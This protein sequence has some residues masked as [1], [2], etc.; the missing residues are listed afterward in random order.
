MAD[1]GCIVPVSGLEYADEHFVC[2][3]Y[4]NGRQAVLGFIEKQAGQLLAYDALARSTLVF[5][6][7]G[8]VR[9]FSGGTYRDLPAG[10]MTLVSAGDGFYGEARTDFLLV[11]CSFSRDMPLCNKFALESLSA[12]LPRSGAPAGMGGAVLPVRPLLSRYLQVAVDVLRICMLCAHYQRITVE[13]VFLLLRGF[14]TKEELALLFRPVLGRDFDFRD[15]LL[16]AYSVRITVKELASAMDMSLATF[17]RRFL[18]AFGIP[19]GQWLVDKKKERLLRD[20]L[21]TKDTVAE[22]ADKYGMSPNYLSSF[23]KEHFGLPPSE[24]R[25]GS[26]SR[27]LPPQAG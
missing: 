11:Y 2:E 22:L 18:A 14:Y 21:V 4:S 9:I 7:S 24:I 8:E 10:S 12:F 5:V 17:N 27:P 3:N 26:S 6:L 16:G 15:K 20:L 1:M 23:C 19:A 13:T 25:S